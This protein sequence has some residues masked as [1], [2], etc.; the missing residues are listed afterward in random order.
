[1]IILDKDNFN[2]THEG[3]D[4]FFTWTKALATAYNSGK[5]FANGW[6]FA[7]WM[8][9]LSAILKPDSEVKKCAVEEWK[10][11]LKSELAL[12]A[13]INSTSTTG[14]PNPNIAYDNYIGIDS[15]TMSAAYA[16]TLGLEEPFK[17]QTIDFI[18]QAHWNLLNPKAARW[19]NVLRTWSGWV[20][21]PPYGPNP[22]NNYFLRFSGAFL[23]WHEIIKS[24]ET[25]KRRDWAFD[26]LRQHAA[27]MKG[28]GSLEGT[29]YGRADSGRFE[30][31][32]MWS[33]FTGKPIPQEVISYAEDYVDY[34]CHA[35]YP[36][37]TNMIQIGDQS[38]ES[39]H[40]IS[41]GDRGWII[42]VGNACEI[43]PARQK[44]VWLLENIKPSYNV[45]A[46]YLLYNQ[47]SK[48]KETSL[49][50]TK[51]RHDAA[52]VGHYFERSDFGKLDADYFAFSAGPNEETHE[53]HDQGSLWLA[54]SGVHVLTSQNSWSHSGI[55]QAAEL[56]NTVAFQVN[57]QF[58]KQVRNKTRPLVTVHPNGD[59]TADLTNT[60]P[61]AANGTTWIRHI[62]KGVKILTVIDELTL[63][64]NVKAFQCWN[65]PHKFQEVDSVIGIG[66]VKMI[67]PFEL[68]GDVQYIDYKTQPNN[69]GLY[70]GFGMRIPLGSG[71]HYTTFSLL[72]GFVKSGTPEPGG[73]GGNSVE[74]EAALAKIKT[75]E[76]TIKELTDEKATLKITI[77]EL[78]EELTHRDKIITDLNKNLTDS[79]KQFEKAV[80][81]NEELNATIE[82]LKIGNLNLIDYQ[83]FFISLKNLLAKE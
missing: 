5:T 76:T 69:I 57:G 44:A 78:N 56:Q 45:N 35:V 53:A 80:R 23:Y 60:I 67:P 34:L 3:A 33:N 8:A 15:Y 2:L 66:P 65:S 72:L 62:K 37:Q 32:T 19:N 17:T 21:G 47:L 58:L 24:D 49:M 75:L 14:Q 73:N 13:A 4:R 46:G 50:P 20:I 52:T 43:E 55:E 36:F 1:M 64:P 77:E 31:W 59:I 7:P 11:I 16:I 63:A 38:N 27:G 40:K 9:G 82:Q 74:L 61:S 26:L 42:Q 81:I 39:S 30:L 68:G 25:L 10:K 54:S 83:N 6:G 28:G 18:N 12:I 41:E 29:G 48:P 51:V 70:G 22:A 71:K 79:I